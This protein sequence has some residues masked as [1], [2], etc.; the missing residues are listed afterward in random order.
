[1][2]PW[3]ALPESWHARRTCPRPGEASTELGEAP[4]PLAEGGRRRRWRA[5]GRHRIQGGPRPG[6]TDDLPGHPGRGTAPQRNV[7]DTPGH[8]HGHHQGGQEPLRC[9]PAPRRTRPP[10]RQPPAQPC[11]GPPTALPLPP[12]ARPEHIRHWPTRPQPPRHRG[13]AQGGAALLG[14][15][16]ADRYGRQCASRPT[17]PLAGHG[18][19]RHRAGDRTGR[20]RRL[21]GACA[22]QGPQGACLR[23]RC[24][25]R[26]LGGPRREA[27][28]L[29]GA[30]AP[31]GPWGWC[32]AQHGQPPRRDL[33]CAVGHGPPA[34]PD[35]P[36]GPHRRRAPPPAS[37]SARALHEGC[38]GAAGPRAA[39]GAASPASPPQWTRASV[40]GVWP[41]TRSRPPLAG[42]CRHRAAAPV[43]AQ[44]C[45]AVGR[46]PTGR[47]RSRP[48]RR[49]RR[50]GG[51]VA[52]LWPPA[53]AASLQSLR[54]PRRARTLAEP[55]RRGI[56]ALG[57]VPKRCIM[58]SAWR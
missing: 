14:I 42:L 40:A 37:G 5:V 38:V 29:L 43:S 35:R 51:R 50:C 23:P 58:L 24:P 41:A 48:K 30:A 12:R 26:P 17:S 44:P 54:D 6:C 3:V 27:P 53:R 8:E 15:D 31:C 55:C 18:R 46:L 47:S 22:G 49:A 13:L 56:S 16:R 39:P 33:A 36:G 57:S 1:V 52:C 32:P 11:E 19:R 25:A 7:V 20:P 45:H 34:G 10:V 21:A 28:R 2:P 4:H 9:L